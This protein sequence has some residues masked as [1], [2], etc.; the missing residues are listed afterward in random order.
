MCANDVGLHLFE[1]GVIEPHFGGLAAAQVVPY[2]VT[3]LDQ[4]VE[5]RSALV[6]FQVQRDAFL[7]EIESLKVRAIVIR[8]CHRSRLPRGVSTRRAI[9]NFDHLGTQFGQIHR[10]VGARAELFNGQY[11]NASEWF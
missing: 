1:R 10:A 4:I 8:Q 2:D 11:A 5:E 9:L 7:G 3:G 6:T